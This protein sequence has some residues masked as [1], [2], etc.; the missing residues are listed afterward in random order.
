MTVGKKNITKKQNKP[1]L[2]IGVSGGSISD[3]LE[4]LP[5]DFLVASVDW[6][7]SVTKVVL[8]N[9]L[10][11]TRLQA[12]SVR[13]SEDTYRLFPILRSLLLGSFF[14]ILLHRLLALLL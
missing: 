6:K 2:E 9:S 4:L 13:G 1:S 5:D 12:C 3:S 14:G 11:F 8:L 7:G 10:T